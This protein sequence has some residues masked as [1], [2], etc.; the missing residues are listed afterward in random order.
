MSIT[1][2]LDNVA[3][4]GPVYPVAPDSNSDCTKGFRPGF[5]WVQ[6][7]GDTVKVFIAV[8]TDRAAAVWQQL[9]NAAA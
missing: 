9:A 2:F 1:T 4:Q 6:V 5:V 3:T 8:S 7:N